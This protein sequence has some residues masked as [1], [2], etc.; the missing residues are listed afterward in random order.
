MAG[1]GRKKLGHVSTQAAAAFRAGDWWQYKLTPPLAMFWATTIHSGRPLLP[2]WVEAGALVAAIAACAAYVSLVNDHFD[3]DED[4]RSGKPNQLARLSR[5]AAAAL[6]ALVAGAGLLFLWLWRGD[7]GI[8]AA[9]LGSWIAFTLYSAPP[10]RLKTRGLPGVLADASGASLLPAVLAVLLAARA[11]AQAPD[12]AWLAAAAAWAFGWGLRGIL[13][14]QLGDLDSDRRGRVLTFA[15]RRG[16]RAARRLSL[17]LALPLELA[18]LAALL[19]QLG[20][21]LPPLFLLLY[22]ALAGARAHFWKAGSYR[23]LLLD[24]YYDTLLPLALLLGSGARHPADLVLIVPLL[25]LSGRRAAR[26]AADSGR[27]ARILRYRLAARAGTYWP[28]RREA[29][30]SSAKPVVRASDPQ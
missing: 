9:Y 10:A 24:E 27:F 22:L 29:R 25:L 1:M 16:A 30:A 23:P 8:A 14:H 13:W 28:A 26:V 4:A 6:F 7:P 5:G 20:S 2:S 18:G 12:P 3:R 19:W 15:Q 11:D 17:R 21:P